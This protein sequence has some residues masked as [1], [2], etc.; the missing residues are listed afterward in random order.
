[1]GKCPLNVAMRKSPDSRLGKNRGSD[2]A[3]VCVLR[4]AE[5]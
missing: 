2:V 1:M 4:K 3:A 5:E